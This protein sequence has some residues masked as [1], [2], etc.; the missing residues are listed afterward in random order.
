MSDL[1]GDLWLLLI[2]LA[3]KIKRAEECVDRIRD[4]DDKELVDDFLDSGERL[5]E[6]FGKILKGCE[7]YMWRAASREAKRKGGSAAA[8]MGSRSGCE[9]VDSIFGRDRKLEDT[10]KLMQGMR[11]WSMRFDVNCEEILRHPSG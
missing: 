5:W 9:F 6:R 10:E 4:I 11:L 8:S 1:A 3:G 7:E 2:Q